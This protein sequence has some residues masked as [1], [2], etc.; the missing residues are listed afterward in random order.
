VTFEDSI[1]RAFPTGEINQV[2][3]QEEGLKRKVDL[4]NK[5]KNH[6]RRKLKFPF[7]PVLSV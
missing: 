2:N 3:R 1:R 5:G 6:G 7:S 4:E